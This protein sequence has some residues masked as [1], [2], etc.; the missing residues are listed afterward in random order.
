MHDG[1]DIVRKGR[2]ATAGAP[3]CGRWVGSRPLRTDLIR[4]APIEGTSILLL[5]VV[6]LG[7]VAGYWYASRGLASG[8]DA[9]LPLEMAAGQDRLRWNAPPEDTD[10]VCG[11]SI[12]TVRAKPSLH[13]GWV[14]YFCSQECREVFEAAPAD[15]IPDARPK[16]L[17]NTHDPVGRSR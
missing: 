10:P 11:K 8:A 9:R 3:R 16:R 13:D 12:P 15:Y 4:R 2:R 5:L 14:Y 1:V 7:F 6:S 17:T